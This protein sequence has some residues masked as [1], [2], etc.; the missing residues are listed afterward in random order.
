MQEQKKKLTKE[1]S[2]N[3]IVR[4]LLKQD[5]LSF[6]ID[7]I[8]ERT[9]VTHE[10]KQ[11]FYYTAYD[12][13]EADYLQINGWSIIQKENNERYEYRY[14]LRNEDDTIYECRTFSQVRRD[15]EQ[16]F[17]E[18]GAK[19]IALA[20]KVARVPNDIIT[21]GVYKIGVAAKS[22]IDQKYDYVTWSEDY[23]LF[24]LKK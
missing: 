5:A 16:I 6:S 9:S 19:N 1:K 8:Q 12:K 21:P 13:E 4:K 24:F 17:A 3:K 23:L 2:S 14:L 10:G 20:G 7:S 11:C 22:L 18:T 15:V